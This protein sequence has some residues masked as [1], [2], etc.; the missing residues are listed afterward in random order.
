MTLIG[1][2]MKASDPMSGR[3]APNRGCALAVMAKAPVAG[4]VKT[5]LVPPLT[6]HE[7]AE[8]NV[9]F[10]RDIAENIAQATVDGVADGL[11]AH[12]PVGAESPF[13][14][15]LPVGFHLLPQRGDSLGHRLFNA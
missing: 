15:L 10:L 2:E 12:T 14:G 7:A 6:M 13:N 9:N 3:R 1:S 4:A 11:F 5:R 8:L